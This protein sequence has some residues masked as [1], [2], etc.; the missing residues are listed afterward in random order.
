MKRETE[1]GVCSTV[2]FGNGVTFNLLV[3]LRAFVLC[4]DSSVASKSKQNNKLQSRATLPK[5]L[6]PVATER[7][8][9]KGHWKLTVQIWTRA[10]SK[11][12]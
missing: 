8:K 6:K 1:S 7:A 11:P 3:E 2:W 5:R 9:A 4:L 10:A 12:Q